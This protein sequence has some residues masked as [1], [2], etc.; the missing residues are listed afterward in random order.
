MSIEVGGINISTLA[1]KTF[2]GFRP[3]YETGTLTLE[4]VNDGLTPISLPQTGI[5]NTNDYVQWIWTD[6]TIEYSWGKKGHLHMI[7]K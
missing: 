7:L 2:I 4:Y 5:T 1:D 6:Q 3:H